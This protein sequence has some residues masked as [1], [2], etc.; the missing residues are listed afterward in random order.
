MELDIYMEGIVAA[1]HNEEVIDSIKPM[2]I[3][4]TSLQ[5]TTEFFGPLVVGGMHAYYE[6]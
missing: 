2:D 5:S 1:E 6:T 3:N 4:T